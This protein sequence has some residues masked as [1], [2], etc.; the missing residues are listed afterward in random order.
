[1][2]TCCDRVQYHKQQEYQLF[3]TGPIRTTTE[4]RG[5]MTSLPVT[6]TGY[7]HYQNHTC[8]NGTCVFYTFANVM[9]FVL[10]ITGNGLVI[11]IA[12]FKM[13]KSVVTTWYLS[14]AMSDFIYCSTLPFGII[15]MV[16]DE[17]IFGRFMCKFRY[18]IKLLNMY[19]SIFLLA[20]ISVDRCV[21][22]KC[23]VWALNHRT[24]RK[25]SVIVTIAW[26]ISAALSSP[27]A[28]F[29]DMQDKHCSRNDDSKTRNFVLVTYRFII[30]FV[31]PFLIIIICYVVIMQKLKSHQMVT[32]KKPFKIMTVLIIAFLICW[33]P[34]HIFSFWK[35]NSKSAFVKD[36][37][38]F[39]STL[40]SANS[41]LNPL[42]YAFM[43]SDFKSQCYT[44]LSNI[45]NAIKE[46][47]EGQE[48]VQ[49][50]AITPLRKGDA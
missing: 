38:V 40:A 15:H 36:G 45:E 29:R 1:R 9:I 49:G 12:G 3:S 14:L 28:I 27:V 31:I 46:E 41:F 22:V 25:A 8:T 50:M 42:L 33:L 43:G 39:G 7:L 44:V 19:S 18:F 13:K 23:P 35:I 10:G 24:I 32:S 34:F 47:D 16:K 5:I 2:Q 21:V 48:R 37:K 17:W 30:G 20:T 6:E 11:W 4:S 26:F